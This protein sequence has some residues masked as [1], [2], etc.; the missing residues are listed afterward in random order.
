MK[1]SFI[2]SFLASMTLLHSTAHG[3][4]IS[5]LPNPADDQSTQASQA[6][7]SAQVSQQ[8]QAVQASGTN[9]AVNLIARYF[10]V[11][12][13]SE[14]SRKSDGTVYHLDLAQPLPLLSVE[15]KVLKGRVKLHEM[16]LITSKGEHVAV[17]ELKSTPVL[18]TG[19]VAQSENLNLN[20]PIAALEIRAESF[21]TEADIV[22]T[23]LS[24]VNK[25]SLILKKEVRPTPP[26]APPMPLPSPIISAGDRVIY[27]DGSSSYVG[28]VLEVFHSG[29]ARVRFDGYSSVSIINVSL[30]GKS[31]N[32]S[33]DA[34]S[35]CR[36]DRVLYS[37][38]SD[39]YVGSVKD[40]FSNGTAQIVFDG[41]SAA[42]PI[43]IKELS[44]TVNCSANGICVGNRVAFNDGSSSY[45]GLVKEVYRNDKVSVVFDGYSSA[46]IMSSKVLGKAQN[47]SNSICRGDRVIYN[48]GSNDF[49]G[50]VVDA[51]SDGKAAVRFDGY[52]ASSFVPA[53]SLGK[54][55]RCDAVSGICEGYRVL[56]S[57]G[58]SK[59]A[60]T[61]QSVFSN[62]KAAVRFDG[63]SA[64]SIL[65][66]ASLIR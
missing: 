32:C 50:S 51:F 3:Q 6:T 1:N 22:I 25:P 14:I 53:N 23:A 31:M 46:S 24:D 58:E 66:A 49:I 36:S 12:T 2:L 17:R 11:S 16:Q 52:S 20:V 60:G 28:T 62:G 47:C 48:N 13:V 39:N 29:D 7:Q 10:G 27:V 56:W 65:A 9:A 41:Y 64:V 30:L 38:G 59:Y 40:V 37:S 42:S 44:K 4:I 34:Y 33:Y 35:I 26:P 15:I 21:Q 18:D 43:R 54:Q 45:T 5:D 19:A 63:Y 61:V 8:T 57:S 55:V